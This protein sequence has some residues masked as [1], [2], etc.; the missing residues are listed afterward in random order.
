MYFV[1]DSKDYIYKDFI[2]FKLNDLKI[3]DSNSKDSV[4]VEVK[5]GKDYLLRISIFSAKTVTKLSLY[6]YL[7]L[8]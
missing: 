5:P 3:E 1:N 2:E 4:E 8:Y 6:D 7:I